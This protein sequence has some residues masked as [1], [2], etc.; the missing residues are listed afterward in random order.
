MQDFDQGKAAISGVINMSIQ[1]GDA[2]AFKVNSHRHQ[3]NG[4]V[5]SSPLHWRCGADD[6][7]R[8][9]MCE[10]GEERCFHLNIFAANT[11]RFVAPDASVAQLVASNP[12]LLDDQIIF[13][14]GPTFDLK[15]G[16]M[17][18]YAEQTLYGAYRVKR[19]NLATGGYSRKPNL[20]I[21]PYPDGWAIFPRNLVRKPATPKAV[22]GVSYLERISARAASDAIHEAYSASQSSTGSSSLS[23]AQEKQLKLFAEC[24][25]EWSVIA[26]KHLEVQPLAAERT[27]FSTG[28]EKVESPMAATL[29]AWIRSKNE[30]PAEQVPPSPEEAPPPEQ[31]VESSASLDTQIT[32]ETPPENA[33]AEAAEA[34][35]AIEQVPW[36]RSGLP[37][38]E[39]TDELLREY[40]PRLLSALQVA[41][42]TKTLLIIT[43]SPG[44]GKSWLAS[45][46]INDMARERSEIVPVSST[47][48]GREDLLGYVNPVNGE[49]EPT[50]FTRFLRRA[51][52]AW[53]SGDRRTWLIV[54]E[55][56]N[57][58]QPEHWLSDLLVRLEY[59]PERRADRTIALGGTK[60]AGEESTSFP[61]VFLPP[62]L[63]LIAT[64]NNDHTVRPLSPR[65]LDRAALIEISATGRVALQRVGIEVSKDIEEVVEELNDLLEVRGVA[66]SVRSARSLMR[67]TQSLGADK[68]MSILDHVLVQEVLSKVRL[69]AGDP[70]DEQLLARLREWGERPACDELMLC[71]E[72]ISVWDESLQAGRDVF[73]A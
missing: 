26:K 50:S 61:E 62:N 21:E 67:A 66:F 56:F 8:E 1:P 41:T 39:C 5:C 23:P 31:T 44:V 54:F 36:T 72:R 46:L 63:I 7:F 16:R 2:F 43:G 60:I 17:D 53:D 42:L 51:E 20:V 37:E 6:R 32:S 64:L 25:D 73:Q 47:W 59:D 57:L 11:P 38:A 40:G 22:D 24:F 71:R 28:E 27:R 58:S 29:K 19:A 35:S 30:A 9:T 45:R 68:T 65:V 34:P 18:G 10:R 14:Y 52:Q 69:M 12:E 48:R 70:R 49:F 4:Q 13:F 3:W 55:E 33:D 15:A